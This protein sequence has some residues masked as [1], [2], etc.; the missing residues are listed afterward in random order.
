MPKGEYAWIDER[1]NKI[2]SCSPE[3]WKHLSWRHHN[4]ETGEITLYPAD[5]FGPLP[6]VYPPG[7]KR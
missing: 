2:R 3:A 5:A 6:I 7:A 4:P 1:A